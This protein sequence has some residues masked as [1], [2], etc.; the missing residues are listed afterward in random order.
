MKRLLIG[1]AFFSFLSQA[2]AQSS[3]GVDSLRQQ[4]NNVFANLDKSQVPTG[5]LAGYGVP[6]VS[7]EALNGTLVD[8]NR[9]NT[10][11]WRQAYATLITS[12]IYGTATLPR[13]DTLA[14]RLDRASAA[15][16]SI[17]IAIERL[18]YAALRP[19]AVSAG[20]LTVQNGQL[21]DVPGRSQ[22]PYQVRT[23]FVAGPARTYSRDGNVS[24]VFPQNLHV[25]NGAGSV[26]T[27]QLDFGDGQGYHTAA[28]G[29]PLSTVYCTAGT[30]RV[31]VRVS[32]YNSNFATPRTTEA[33]KAAA[34]IQQSSYESH[35]DLVV[36][37]ST[38]GLVRY[39]DLTTPINFGAD[40]ST[41]GGT[42]T[43]RYGADHTQLTKPL[44]VVEGYDIAQIAP[45]LVPGGNY[46]IQDFLADINTT[47]EST[48]AGL[49][50]FGTSLD[51]LAGYDIVFID[52]ANGTDAIQR[53]AELFQRVVRWVNNTKVID[54]A[55][56]RRQ[57]NVVLGISMGGLVARYGLAQMVKRGN[58]DPDTRLLA[59]QDSPHRGAN[60]PLGLQAVTRQAY[61]AA[62][63]YTV[64]NPIAGITIRAI[65]PHLDQANDVLNAPATQQMLL[66]YALN[67]T[68][69][70]V[71][72]IFLATDYRNTVT[73]P[74]GGPQPSYSFVAVSLGSQCGRWTLQPYSELVR[75]EAGGFLWSSPFLRT[76]L[77]VNSVINALPHYANS[78][79]VANLRL[80]VAFK[81]LNIPISQ[82]LFNEA[83]HSPANVPCWDGVPG[84]TQS[85]S[86][87]VPIGTGSGSF[88]WFVL[89]GD[90]NV[91]AAE[92]F[93]FVPTVSALDI[94]DITP[95]SLGGSYIDGIATVSS[96]RAANFIAQPG[97]P[98][99]FNFQ[100]PFFQGRQSH[101]LFNIMESGLGSTTPLS[102]NTECSPYPIVSIS[103]PSIICPGTTKT[104]T[105]TPPF[106]SVTGWTISPPGLVTI[107]GG[108]GGSTTLTLT[109][110]PLATGKIIIKAQL[111]SGCF[112]SETVPF[113]VAVGRGQIT[114]APGNASLEI[115]K[116]TTVTATTLGI[117][118]PF[119]WEAIM[120]PDPN[121]GRADYPLASNS[122]GFTQ[123]IKAPFGDTGNI[124]ITC[125]GTD[126][127]GNPVVGHGDVHVYDNANP[128]PINRMA[129]S[130]N[131]YPNPAHNSLLLSR[132][133]PGTDP[134]IVRLFD[135]Y[136]RER[137]ST[138]LTG[139][140]LQLDTHLLPNGI[141]FLH[142][143]KGG[144]THR[145]QIQV[146]H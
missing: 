20:L 132:T 65:F 73:F 111:S 55:I 120:H 22:S 10:D 127:C 7:L 131:V 101:W 59:T 137:S 87:R 107:A 16:S 144:I 143:T 114:L 14:A 72:P 18:N 129:T 110:E 119:V 116:T 115:G 58:D 25:Q 113:E 124:H 27:I 15:S 108:G 95:A 99:R 130:V 136:S 1:L 34:P 5:Y 76:A 50:T 128:D 118:P 142:V 17:P 79:R 106:G 104:F 92:S 29:Q 146:S 78:E 26:S 57:Q 126:E 71:A 61:T 91:Q 117:S 125:S 53:N 36:A 86:S 77:R 32:Y 102:C 43:V 12:Q 97:T 11:V 145:Q 138:S 122:T 100:H 84:G 105:V 60:T 24:F 90:I 63:L 2:I 56:G 9:T 64:L 42:V 39:A 45:K 62:N 135:A 19:D 88:D 80:F 48:S 51:D 85:I 121:S 30:Y 6:L 52:Y 67:G 44:I 33:H 82:S 70:M 38:C 96:S 4:I 140:N 89:G 112:S 134:I 46:G 54:P 47:S 35:F 103:G 81:I 83:F 31:K 139:E 3:T 93:C 28:W 75:I 37:Q 8:S 94:A 69:T 74:A 41:S 141:Y 133:A 123:F 68:G 49:F 21:F 23:L 98:A 109:P 13:L 40:V 66:L